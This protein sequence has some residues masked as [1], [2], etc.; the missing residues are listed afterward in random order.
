VVPDERATIRHEQ[1]V[2]SK[3]FFLLLEIYL[4]LRLEDFKDTMAEKR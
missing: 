3:L 4:S 1:A 2:D